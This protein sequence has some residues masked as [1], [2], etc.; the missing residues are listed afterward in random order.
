MAGN[1]GGRIQTGRGVVPA[2][3]PSAQ[4]TIASGQSQ[5][6]SRSDNQ[7]RLLKEAVNKAGFRAGQ[8][9]AV[10]YMPA[11]KSIVVSAQAPRATNDRNAV[12]RS[13]AV[14]TKQNVRINLSQ[15]GAEK[16]KSFIAVPSNGQ[17]I[18]YCGN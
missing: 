2:P 10:T 16:N 12:T 15:L 4:A 5:V 3:T 1:S 18:I 6:L 9:V 11:A 8:N 7:L 14:D 13:Y 17:V